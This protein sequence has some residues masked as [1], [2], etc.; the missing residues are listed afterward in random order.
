MSLILVVNKNNNKIN[1][2]HKMHNNNNM[3]NNNKFKNNKNN[4][5]ES[6]IKREEENLKIDQ[7]N[8]QS[9]NHYRKYHKLK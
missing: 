3:H 8:K 4:I 9:A 2:N 1:N 6:S 5:K 7:C